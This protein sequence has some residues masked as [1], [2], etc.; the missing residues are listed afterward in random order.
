MSATFR[1]WSFAAFYFGTLLCMAAI[2][3]FLRTMPEVRTWGPVALIGFG[4]LGLPWLW[5]RVRMDE[6]GITQT[7]VRRRFIAWGDMLSWERVGTPGSDGPKT[8]SISTRTGSITLNHNCVYGGRL[9]IVEAELKRR[10]AHP[11]GAANQ[12]QPVRPK[13]NND[14]RRLAPPTFRVKCSISTTHAITSETSSN[15]GAD[16]GRV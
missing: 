15:P 3:C 14:Q 5:A 8:L 16:V 1:S 7:I 2:C 10:I 4:I 11:D 6:Q 13:T 9:D 12:S